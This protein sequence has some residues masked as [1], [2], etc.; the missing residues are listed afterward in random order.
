MTNSDRKLKYSIFL[1]LF[2]S[3]PVP[4]HPCF[5]LN[6]LEEGGGV[7]YPIE[8]NDHQAVAAEAAEKIILL[9]MLFWTF[10]R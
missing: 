5:F 2:L 1:S 7:K 4:F 8:T 6:L 3:I 10:V 9:S